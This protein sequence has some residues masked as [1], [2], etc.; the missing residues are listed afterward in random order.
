MS[1]YK[2]YRNVILEMIDKIEKSIGRVEKKEFIN[3]PELQDATLMRLQVIGENIKNIPLQIKKKYK[4]VSWKK[5]EKLR[6]VISH[7][8]ASVDYNLIWNFLENNLNELKKGVRN[9]E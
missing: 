2:L 7:K 3:S 8:Y 6:N 5:F 4:E 1:E 9:I